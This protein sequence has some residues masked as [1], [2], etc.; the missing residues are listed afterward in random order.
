MDS[1]ACGGLPTA[2]AK[3]KMTELLEEE[4]CGRRAVNYRLRDWGI[5]RQRYWGTPIPMIHC[6]ACGTVP[7]PLEDLPVRLP[8]EGVSITASGG[9]PLARI[10][11][12]RRVKCS[13]CGGEAQRD[14]DT[15]DTFVDSSW[16]FLRYCSPH[17]DSGPVA[18]EEA[19]YWMPVDQ[20]IGGIE[21]AIL[22]LLY[23]RFFTRVM[24]DLGLIGV[25]EPFR[26]LL[27]Q[28]MVVKDGAKMSKS[29]G[30]VV[31]PEEMVKA[32]GADTTRLFS[33]FAAPPEKDLEW[34]D[35][36]VEG[37]F[38]FLSRVW[39]LVQKRQEELREE[40]SLEAA[41]GD[42][43]GDARW[44]EIRR[45]THRTIKKVTV[46]ID[47]RAHFN[48]AISSIMEL[49]NQLYLLEG[50]PAATPFGRGAL[51][52]AVQTVVTLLAPFTPHLA[53]ELWAG[54]GGR[55]SI[56]LSSWPK[57]DPALLVEEQWEIV[58]QISGK[59][60]GRIIVPADSSEEEIRR[61][62]TEN[63]RIREW[64][65]KGTVLKVIYVPGR[66]LNI[67]VR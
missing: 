59:V 41:A 48:T 16:Y 62:A 57:F 36:S 55:E 9:T 40:G 56:F 2:A 6:P 10:E 7:V 1:G 46:D 29:K 32:Y 47:E 18:R 65:E 60:R 63:E 19:D 13:S 45:H 61:V 30:N 25:S 35:E 3:K 14:L 67:V 15:M 43:D 8:L 44:A 24:R 31:S 22:H 26:K 50:C 58:V 17:D 53:E 34:N 27:T 20:Y 38:R 23:A 49:V 4:G 66:L 28:G 42:G 52:E 39:R 51:R 37:C 21:H 12:F 5:S 33:L 11:S 64:I 54:L